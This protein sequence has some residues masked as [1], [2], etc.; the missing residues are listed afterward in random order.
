MAVTPT[1]LSGTDA[2]KLTGN[3]GTNPSLNFIGTSD[4]QPLIFKANGQKAGRID[5]LNTTANTSF[6]FQSLNTNI[7]GI[8]NTVIGYAALGTNSTGNNNTAAGYIA[9]AS[10]T[11]GS[12]NVANGNGALISNTTGSN[13]TGYGSQALYSNSTGTNNTAIGLGRECNFSQSQ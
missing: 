9:L 6:G 1:S 12:S 11:T 3:I 13:N 10:N 5:Y 7:S 2:W 8:N 4:A